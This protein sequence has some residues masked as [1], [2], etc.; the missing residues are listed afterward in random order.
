MSVHILDRSESHV[1]F[2][3]KGHLNTHEHSNTRE[4]P[5]KCKF[6]GKMFP[7]KGVH[8]LERNHEINLNLLIF[9]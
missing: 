4:K 7:E 8:K 5:L 9:D 2:L 1:N 6:W 3:K